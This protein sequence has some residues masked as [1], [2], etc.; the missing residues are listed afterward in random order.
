[1]ELWFLIDGWLTENRHL[2]PDPNYIKL[3]VSTIS[4]IAWILY[5]EI[6]IIVIRPDHV[7]VMPPTT[8]HFIIRAFEP[9][10]YHRLLAAIDRCIDQIKQI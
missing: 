2:L 7:I 5:H 4:G 10:F 1:M 3:K 9:T 6:I 8:E